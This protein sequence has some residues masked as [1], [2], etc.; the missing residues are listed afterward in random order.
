MEIRRTRM[1][2]I[3]WCA[4]TA[5]LA[6][7]GMLEYPVIGTHAD[8]VGQSLTLIPKLG[9]IVFGVY[10]P[11]LNDPLGYFAVMAYWCGLII[12]T[13][14]MYAGASAVAKENRDGTAEYLFTMPCG[15]REIVWAKILAVLF[16]IFIMGIVNTVV[17]VMSMT[18]ITSEPAVYGSVLLACLGMFFMQCLIAALGL[19]CS[20]LF[21]TYRTGVMLAAAVLVISYCLMFAVQYYDMPA[22][23]YISP[24]AF[25]GAWD[26]AENGISLI[27]V[28]LAAVVVGVC[29]FGTQLIYSRREMR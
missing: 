3:V 26:V 14:A 20:S 11:S 21:K 5:C 28:L 27:Y 7:M 23:N 24:L 18:A 29:L 12:F 17:N 4:A 25:F 6:G 22:L 9:Q 16:N 1:G 10:G 13:H 2:L 19:L 15:R 8:L